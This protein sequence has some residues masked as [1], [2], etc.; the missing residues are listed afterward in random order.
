MNT[1]FEQSLISL[2]DWTPERIREVLD[3]AHREKAAYKSGKG[4]RA[5]Q[6]KTVALFF[7]KPSLRTYTTFQVGVSHLGGSCTDLDPQVIQ[8]GKRESIED[9]GRCLGRWVDGI[10]IRCFEQKLIEDFAEHSKVPVINALSDDFHPC[11]ALALA[12]TL[13]EHWSEGLKGKRIVF[14][15]DGNN[16]ANS[17]AI[18]AAKTGMHF[19]LACPEGYEQ[20]AKI[21]T[22]IRALF[23][24][25]HLDFKVTHY[26][27]EAV[28]D[29]D[30]IYTDVW[31]SMG[32]ESEQE[33]R[34]KIFLPFQVNEELM[35]SA[36]KSALVSHCLPAHRGEE[37]THEVLEADYCVCFDEAEN[38]LHAQKGVLL[39]LLDK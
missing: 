39:H 21:C 33:E 25:S 30:L 16:V 26:P 1:F 12:Q 22:R 35:R 19:T 17:F 2:F 14:V 37:I 15:G 10:V 34:K 4:S 32:Q 13:E 18:L 20:E 31:A 24:E 38:R 23:A 28:Q 8:I 36:P 9:I 11:Q 7:E 3:L 5:L 6:G 27:K 29:A